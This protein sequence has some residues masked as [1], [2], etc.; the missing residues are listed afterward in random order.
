MEACSCS[1]CRAPLLVR[2]AKWGRA[3]AHA[4]QA[5]SARGTVFLQRQNGRT[6]CQRQQ[7]ECGLLGWISRLEQHKH[8]AGKTRKSGGNGTVLQIF[9]MS[10]A[11]GLQ[12]IVPRG[13]SVACDSHLARLGRSSA[14]CGGAHGAEALGRLRRA[15]QAVSQGALATAGAQALQHVQVARFV[16]TSPSLQ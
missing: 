3:C 16:P 13:H 14:N 10:C 9:G 8:D 6:C 11:W 5:G 12:Q 1:T 7:L 2:V 15:A 4:V